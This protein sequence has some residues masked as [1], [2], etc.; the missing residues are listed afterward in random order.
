MDAYRVFPRNRAARVDEPGGPLWWPRFH[1]GSGRH[2]NPLDYGC[3]YVSE[4]PVGAAAEVLAAFRSWRVLRQQMLTTRDGPLAI[5]RLELDDDAEII[6]LDLP[7]VLTEEELRPS[8]VATHDREI[9]QAYAASLHGR[10]PRA[11]GI[12]WWS[13]LESL[14]TNLT[15]FDRA[16]PRLAGRPRRLTLDEPVVIEAADFLGLEVA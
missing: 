3:I 9:T 6:N 15:L 13:T 8:F 5:A 7:S 10:H 2:D 12:R 14:W 11:I 16:S 1:Q 4:T